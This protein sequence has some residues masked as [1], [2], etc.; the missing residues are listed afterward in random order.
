MVKPPAEAWKIVQQSGFTKARLSK[1]RTF[2]MAFCAGVFVG[3]GALAAGVVSYDLV[4]IRKNNLGIAK[5]IY[6]LI[7][8]IA[9]VLIYAVGA[10][11][12][13]G[14]TMSLMAAL[15]YYKDRAAAR[16][17]LKNWG[18]VLIGN[19]VGC[20][21]CAYF[22]GYLTDLFAHEPVVSVIKATAE[23]KAHLDFGVVFVRAIPANWLVCLAIVGGAAAE[24][25]AGKFLVLVAPIT[26]FAVSGFE[27]VIANLFTIP[28]GLMMGAN[29]TVGEMLMNNIIPALLG[30]IVGGT[31]FMSVIL[32]YTYTVAPTVKRHKPEAPLP[33]NVAKNLEIPKHFM[34]SLHMSHE[35]AV[36][37]N[38]R[39]MTRDGRMIEVVIHATLLR[40]TEGHPL[41]AMSQVRYADPRTGLADPLQRPGIIVAG[42]DATGHATAIEYVDDTL[43]AMLGYSPDQ[44]GELLKK[45]VSDITAKEDL[46][47]T[48]T[49]FHRLLSADHGSSTGLADAAITIRDA[50]EQ[51]TSAPH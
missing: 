13:T 51:S 42:V 15:L 29:A 28:L 3:F 49:A 11:L 24:D 32:W 33:Y 2:L 50:Q 46:S 5:L 22:F 10:E 23:K 26:L 6:G 27:H 34:H 39:Y 17:L 47:V 14:N 48:D 19:A 43:A 35:E 16:G 25:M 12:F 37:F 44:K 8:P 30:N 40:D 36:E 9:L 31:L 41:K 18:L 45:E 4:D 38:K 20:V 1:G 21:G 7:F